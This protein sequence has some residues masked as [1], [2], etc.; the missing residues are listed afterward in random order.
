[1]KLSG[2]APRIKPESGIV[3]PKQTRGVELFQ[4]VVIDVPTSADLR[5]IATRGG[6]SARL[7]LKSEI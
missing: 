6:I 3:I 2:C 7:D 5:E 4:Q 1:V